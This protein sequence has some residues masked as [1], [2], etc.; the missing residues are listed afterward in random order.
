MRGERGKR[1]RCNVALGLYQETTASA[2]T[3]CD[4]QTSCREA[5]MEVREEREKDLLHVVNQHK[6]FI[7]R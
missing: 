1:R 3:S 4:R 7:V 5:P 2:K 6:V